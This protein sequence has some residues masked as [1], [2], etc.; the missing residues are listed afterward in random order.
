MS[1]DTSKPTGRLSLVVGCVILIVAAVAVFTRGQWW[2]V[3]AASFHSEEEGH[4]PHDDEAAHVHGDDEA[5]HDPHD[6]EAGHDD[7]AEHDDATSIE[8][9]KNGLKNIGFEPFEVQSTDFEKKLVLPAIVAERPGRS[10]IYITAP[11]TGVVTEIHAVE[12]Q[13]IETNS[14]MFEQRL[15]HEELV[16][17]QRDY[18]RT[19]ES[20]DVVNR[21]IARL[22]SL[23]E[24]VVP[25][26]RI[27]EQKYEKQKLEASLHA[28]Q[29][30]LVVHG[31]T[32]EQ[33]KDI[34]QTHQLLRQFVIRAPDHSHSGESCQGE[35]L[36]HVQRLAVSQGEQVATG[37]ELAVIADHCELFVEGLAFEDDAAGLRRAARN[38]WHIDADLLLGDERASSVSGLKLLYLADHVDSESR[39]FRFYLQLPNEVV[40]DQ[41]TDDGRRF[42]EWRFKPG[43][44]MQLEVPVDKWEQQLVLPLAAVV[45]EAA[46]SYVYQQNGD[47]F[48]QVSVHVVY[49]DQKSVVVANN[50]SLFPGDI[51]AGQGAYQM[52]LALKNKSGGGIDPHAGHNH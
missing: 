5:G 22:E 13:A 24:G 39:A 47:H 7:H 20:L 44:R 46:E 35:H 48:D 9:S 45:D 31:I 12:G 52:H 25:G 40:L 51:I 23:G 43:Q 50:G 26:R 16:T 34:L 30:A 21:E 19:A 28:E 17:A 6:D 27:L 42:V 2:P 15:T 37:D 49:R 36:F 38:G 4:D 33:V 3:V 14:L 8:L 10:R 32:Q 1:H 11:I 29:Q 41:T 18:L